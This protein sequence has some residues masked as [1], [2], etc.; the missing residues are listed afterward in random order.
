M[1]IVVIQR[2]MFFL[3]IL[4]QMKNTFYNSKPFLICFPTKVE[5]SIFPH[6]TNGFFLPVSSSNV[7]ESFS[8]HFVFFLHHTCPLLPQPYSQPF[9]F[10]SLSQS[11]SLQARFYH[12]QLFFLSFPSRFYA[13]SILYNFSPSFIFRTPINV[14]AF[15]SLLFKFYISPSP[16][17]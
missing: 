9:S 15:F 12:S 4:E 3:H 6:Y 11:P 16:S 1:H 13:P 8:T 5:A 2:Y 14:W 17:P 10:L 7:A